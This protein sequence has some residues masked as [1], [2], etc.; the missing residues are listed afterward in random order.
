VKKVLKNLHQKIA[1]KNFVL[2]A[3][4]KNGP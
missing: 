1:A 2:K 4:Q 3:A